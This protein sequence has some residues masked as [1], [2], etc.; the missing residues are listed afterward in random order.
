MSILDSRV[1]ADSYEKWKRAVL[2]KAYS[3]KKNM[4]ANLNRF[5]DIDY[6]NDI[7]SNIEESEGVVKTEIKSK[8]ALMNNIFI[9]LTEAEVNDIQDILAEGND[10]SD[11]TSDEILEIECNEISCESCEMIPLTFDGDTDTSGE[12]NG[13][14]D[15][16]DY[17]NCA[18]VDPS[19]VLHSQIGSAEDSLIYLSGNAPLPIPFTSKIEDIVEEEN[20][21]YYTTFESKVGYPQN[22]VSTI[23]D[24][25][26][27]AEKNANMPQQKE[28]SSLF[29]SPPVQPYQHPLLRRIFDNLY[30]LPMEMPPRENEIHPD[31]NNYLNVMTR[32]AQSRNF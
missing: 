28:T 10:E 15:V 11:P 17:S 2:P 9:D 19:H 26:I 8:I 12:V 29:F 31:A 22:N 13:S 32:A 21:E 3:S 16:N 20:I 4:Q 25:N 6:C 14:N 30:Q 1:D 24:Q 5:G 7:I 27:Y 23:G 18:G